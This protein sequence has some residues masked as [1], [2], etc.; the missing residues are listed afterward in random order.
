V[1]SETADWLMY[2]ASVLLSV[3]AFLY[4]FIRIFR[5]GVNS[6]K[7]IFREMSRNSY[8]VY[9]IHMIVIGLFM[10]I[11]MHMNIPAW[12]KF[13]LVS[14]LSFTISN[15]LVSGYR[16]IFKN[17]F[18]NNYL[19]Y[20]VVPTSILLS[21]VVYAREEIAEQEVEITSAHYI[22]AIR[23][24]EAALIGDS[25]AI[26]YYINSGADLNEKDAMGGSSP[27]IIAA[28]MG[29]TE[30]AIMLIEAGAD[31]NQLN[32][33]GSTALI[34]AAFFCR[35]EIVKSLLAYGADKDIRNYSGSTAYESVVTDFAYVKEIYDYLSEVYKPLGLELDYD[36]LSKTRPL[37]AEM[38]MNYGL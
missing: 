11:F 15:L 25:S 27:L 16:L 6:S 29:R 19:V 5:A 22:P 37:I 36:Y 23:I 20:A 26:L 35:T 34:T 28:L 30:V 7:K 18:S 24:H 2:Y 17:F 33:E 3:F 9:I 21:I 10:M 12:V 38:I 14:I 31:V 8:S 4:I 1:V 13:V 32:D